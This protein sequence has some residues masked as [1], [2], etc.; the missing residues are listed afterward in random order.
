MLA[1]KIIT[2]LDG[3]KTT[4]QDRWIARCPTHDDKSPSLAIR[5]VD[6]RLLLHCFAGCE[7]YEIVS[8]LGMELSDLFPEKINTGNK[9]LSRPF[10]AADILRCLS[11]EITFLVVCASDLAKGEKLNQ[12][13]KDRLLVSA[14]RFRSALTAGGLQ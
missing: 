14:S 4:G 8:A 11:Y 13:D 1:E 6:D 3:V 12:E 9:P 5:E 10:P 2:Q 7:A